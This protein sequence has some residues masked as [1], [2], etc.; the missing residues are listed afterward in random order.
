MN[1]AAS[2][3]CGIC[4]TPARTPFR[5]PAPEIAPDLDMRPGE[6]AW[7][8]LPDWIQ[9]CASCGAAAPDLAALPESVKPV[10]QSA[11]YRLMSLEGAEESLPFRRW[12]ALCRAT[13]D[14]AGA[15]EATLQAAWAADDAVAMLEASKLRQAVAQAWGDTQ[16]EATALRRLDVLRRSSDFAAAEAWGATLASRKLSAAGTAIVAFQRERIRQRDIGRHLVTS[17]LPK[18]VSHETLGRP[19]YWTWLFREIG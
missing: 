15:I 11:E 5:A 13:G 10:V 16:D 4:G 12:A 14:E 2:P 3:R 8:T 9:T 18:G 17:A 6:P 1:G 19:A 7:E